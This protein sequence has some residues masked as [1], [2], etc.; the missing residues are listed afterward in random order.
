M[1]WRL[2]CWVH[3]LLSVPLPVPVRRPLRASPV[4][5]LLANCSLPMLAASVLAYSSAH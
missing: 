4:V 2:V 5:A 3:L 1:V